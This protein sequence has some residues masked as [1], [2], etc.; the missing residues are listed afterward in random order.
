MGLL[1]DLKSRLGFGNREEY[2]D[3]EPYSDQDYDEEG[4]G[5]DAE[6]D[7]YDQD[8]HGRSGRCVGEYS[9]S[10][11]MSSRGLRGSRQESSRSFGVDRSEYHSD[12]H[13][14]LVS[15]SDVRSQRGASPGLSRQP[16]DRIPTPTPI[17]RGG[18]STLANDDP[19][20][21]REGLARSDVNSL[22]FLQKERQRLEGAAFAPDYDDARARN[23]YEQ[24]LRTSRQSYPELASSSRS[25]RQLDVIKPLS[26]S[27]AE[28]VARCLKNG[29]VAVISLTETRP[30][31]AKRILDFSFGVAS[32]LDAVVDR[33]ADRVF[34]ITRGSSLTADEREL[35][36]ARG[37]R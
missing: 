13:A 34:V 1:D 33:Y 4:Y 25:T 29:N 20:A 21:Y 11:S 12:D 30:E 28:Q 17:R 24:P 18:T 22:S 26:Y 37:I 27:D 15:L 31:L 6:G 32:A 14:P 2:W 5:Y 23:G 35:L 16:Q 8:G 19:Y 7:A 36:R 3:E 9:R 10:G